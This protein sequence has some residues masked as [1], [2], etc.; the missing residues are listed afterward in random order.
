MESKKEFRE[1]TTP[2]IQPFM[3]ISFLSTFLTSNYE[4]GD[5]SRR[6]P[7]DSLPDAFS[8]SPQCI[9]SCAPDSLIEAQMSPL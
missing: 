7:C 8:S 2:E 3:A 4:I 5:P 6:Q 9:M 1:Y